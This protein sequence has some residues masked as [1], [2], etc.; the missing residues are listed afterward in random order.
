M[1]SE[2]RK[3]G[4]DVIREMPW[5]THICLFY[6]TTQ[7]L[8]GTLVPYFKAGLEGGEF[9][10]WVVAE[11]LTSEAVDALKGAVCPTSIDI[12]QIPPWRSCPYATGIFRAVRSTSRE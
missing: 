3:T 7:D 10:L 5:G 6:E 4:I 2:M 11:P 9:C 8:L 1:G 12:W